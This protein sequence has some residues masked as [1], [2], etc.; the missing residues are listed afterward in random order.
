MSGHLFIT[1]SLCIISGVILI[2]M[3]DTFL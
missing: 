3:S 1:S 2:V